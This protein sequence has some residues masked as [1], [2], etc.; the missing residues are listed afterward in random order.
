MHLFSL[1]FTMKELFIPHK[2]GHLMNNFLSWTAEK[3]ELIKRHIT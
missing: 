2:T 1:H 3:T